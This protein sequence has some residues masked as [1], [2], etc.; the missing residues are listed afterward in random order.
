M[1]KM[2]LIAMLA[3]GMTATAQ[4]EKEDLFNMIGMV[5]QEKP[6]T[7]G[8]MFYALLPEDNFAIVRNYVEIWRLDNSG[9]VITAWKVLKD[10]GFS[11]AMV[12]SGYLYVFLFYEDLFFVSISKSK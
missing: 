6:Q 4:T 7:D 12:V 1:R 8:S 11:S 5:I 3:I 9:T 2:L 10:G